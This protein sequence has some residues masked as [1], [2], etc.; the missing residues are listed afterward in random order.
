MRKI[1]V[2]ILVMLFNGLLFGQSFDYNTD[3]YRLRFESSKTETESEYQKLYSSFRKNLPMSDQEVLELMIGFTRQPSYRPYQIQEKHRELLGYVVKK[4]D[5]EALKVAEEILATD[6]LNYTALLE[7][8]FLLQKSK[9]DSMDYYQSLFVKVENAILKSGDGSLE[10]P[11]FVLYPGDGQSILMLRQNKKITKAGTGKDSN[12]FFLEAIDI[13]E[14]EGPKTVFFMITHA[15]LRKEGKLDEMEKEW[16][17][18]KDVEARMN[19]IEAELESREKQVD[20]FIF[21]RATAEVDS[22]IQ[23]PAQ[24]FINKK[25]ITDSI[26]YGEKGQLLDGIINKGNNIIEIRDSNNRLVKSQILSLQGMDMLSI[27]V[28]VN[29][30]IEASN[31]FNI[32]I[33]VKEGE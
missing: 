8:A 4:K 6:P 33:T 30:Y 10:K 15:R 27:E 7:K 5:R 11:Y 14:K 9:M 18:R 3:F 17:Y 23:L 24:L 22:T 32:S 2:F 20:A 19:E 28:R 16:L 25:A 13:S 29:E 26:V 1:G 21:L 31:Y 12:G